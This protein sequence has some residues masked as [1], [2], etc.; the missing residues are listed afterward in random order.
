[1]R[2]NLRRSSYV[3]KPGIHSPQPKTPPKRRMKRGGGKKKGKVETG[4]ARQTRSRKLPVVVVDYAATSPRK[5]KVAAVI[6][7]SD[8]ES[9]D[10]PDTI[11]HIRVMA[12]RYSAAND[13]SVGEPTVG[14]PIAAAARRNPTV[15]VP[16]AASARRNPTVGVPTAT[17]ARRNDTA[18]DSSSEGSVSVVGVPAS[19]PHAWEKLPRLY[20]GFVEEWLKPKPYATL[21]G[22]ER[23]N[24]NLRPS[25]TMLRMYCALLA[26]YGATG[27]PLFMGRGS[28][29][30]LCCFKSEYNV[31]EARKM[32]VRCQELHPFLTNKAYLK[33]TVGDFMEHY[34][35]GTTVGNFCTQFAK[36]G[37]W[38]DNKVFPT[39]TTEGLHRNFKKHFDA[40]AYIWPP[41][42][43][44]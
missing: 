23:H 25:F 22:T 8:P 37:F 44:A 21:V 26:V 32:L 16:T 31:E 5:K 41:R 42:H 35:A 6:R 13:P 2:V 18:E 10:T 3:N 24:L 20:K 19:R 33:E 14:V 39:G 1:M 30:N 12:Q 11:Q 43:T 7:N 38:E 27:V 34:M 9:A 40:I 36:Y 4:V 17:A 29:I 28:L 15:G